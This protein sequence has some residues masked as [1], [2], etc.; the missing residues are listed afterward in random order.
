MFHK[1]IWIIRTHIGARSVFVL[2]LVVCIIGIVLLATGEL[3]QLTPPDSYIIGS[4]TILL[5]LIAMWTGKNPGT[6]K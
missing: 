6:N 5:G 1:I 3:G 4:L 2:G